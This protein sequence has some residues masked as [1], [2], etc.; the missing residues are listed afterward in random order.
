MF[1]KGFLH[2]EQDYPQRTEK[3]ACIV[4]VLMFVCIES[5]I[6]P[7]NN[8]I[9]L[10]SSGLKVYN[11]V[12][13]GFC[14]SKKLNMWHI[15]LIHFVILLPLCLSFSSLQSATVDPCVSGVSQYEKQSWEDL[16]LNLH[17]GS[18]SSGLSCPCISD[19]TGYGSLCVINS[20]SACHS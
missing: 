19:L 7:H 10:L 3:S 16:A 17:K 9:N 6:P 12:L 14:V 1:C 11:P 8:C 5:F 20:P 18:V 4:S 15:P 2:L 13:Q